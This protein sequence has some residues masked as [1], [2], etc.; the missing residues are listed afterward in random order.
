[1]AEEFPLPR[2][3]ARLWGREEMSRRGPRPSVDLATI[4]AS[5]IEIADEG[6]LG[7]VSMSRVAEGTG[8]TTMALYRYVGSKDELL[9]L[10]VDAALPPP[11]EPDGLSWRAYLTRWALGNR[12]YLLRHPWIID[13]NRV[14]PP[15]GPSNMRWLDRALGVLASVGVGPQDA[16]R[17]VT[18][19]SGYAMSQ[20]A[21]EW[22]IRQLAP[23]TAERSGTAHYGALLGRLLDAEDFPSLSRLVRDDVFDGEG[24]WEADEDFLFGLNL[25]LDGVAALVGPSAAGALPTE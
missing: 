12:D 1:M 7:A 15:I 16:I 6:G 17:I 4:T 19:L 20:A 14:P 25:L 5:A 13:L 9:T 23:E 8:V 11:P 24:G 10:M 2:I 21:L 3:V 22:G 18:T